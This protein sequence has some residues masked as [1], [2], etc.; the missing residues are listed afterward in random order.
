MV[1]GAP[2]ADRTLLDDGAASETAVRSFLE[3][4]QRG[5]GDMIGDYLVC[6]GP[7]GFDPGQIATDVHVWHG[8]RDQLVPV[9]HALALA[10]A[11]PRSRLALDPD[12]GHFFFRRRVAEILEGVAAPFEPSSAML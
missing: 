3:A 1:S 8:M 12:D 2:P 5:V 9:D 4:A 11:V 7:W 6:R 10:T